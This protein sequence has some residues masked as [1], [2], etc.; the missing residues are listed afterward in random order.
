MREKAGITRA[1]IALK[2]RIP[3]RTIEKLESQHFSEFPG[4]RLQ[5]YLFE[6]A[7]VLSLDLADV[8]RRFGLTE[9]HKS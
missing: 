1:Q 9:N 3:A 8:S 4:S 2:T 5:A 6:I 7:R